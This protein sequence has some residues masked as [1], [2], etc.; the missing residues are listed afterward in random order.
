MKLFFKGSEKVLDALRTKHKKTLFTA[1]PV[2]RLYEPAFLL[3]HILS[4]SRARQIFT[5]NHI[6][7]LLRNGNDFTLPAVQTKNFHFGAGQAVRSRDE[8]CGEEGF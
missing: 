2:N 1:R 8:F 7:S 4:D 5:V 3:S 6:Q